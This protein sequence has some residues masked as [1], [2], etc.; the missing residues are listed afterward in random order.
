MHSGA[1]GWLGSP[2]SGR[3]IAELIQVAMILAISTALFWLVWAYGNA[4]RDPRYLDGWI[5][6]VGM[7][8]QLLFHIANR[9][10]WLR[11]AAAQRWRNFHVFAGY[12][13][14]P[15]LISHTAFTLP[16][17]G[18]EWALWGGF[19]LIASSGVFGVYLA[20]F[21]KARIKLDEHTGYDH[22]PSRRTELARELHAIVAGTGPDEAASALPQVPY[23]AWIR[24]LYSNELREFFNGPRN[25]ASHLAGSQQPLQHL[26]DEIDQL[27]RYVDGPRQVKLEAIRELVVKKNQQ[28]IALVHLWL[29]RAWPHIHV[30]VTYGVFVLAVLHV[31]VVYSFSSG[32]W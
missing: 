32:A 13:L 3:T 11:P 8:L 9:R 19:V 28:D 20:W 15:V 30:P 24:D 10:A 6:A 22:I 27:S 7:V 26:T 18:L 5:L 14:I 1:K 25:L 29:A 23:D 16:D 17:T 12:L 31:L 2:S 4:L 21:L